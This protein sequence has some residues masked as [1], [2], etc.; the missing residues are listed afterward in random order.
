MY[1]NEWLTR[2]DLA[3]TGTYGDVFVAII[4]MF[5]GMLLLSYFIQ[6]HDMILTLK[7]EV[8]SLQQAPN[9]KQSCSNPVHS[10]DKEDR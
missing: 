7:E 3:I 9:E 10:L 8:E 4:V 1:S 5:A 6:L 2:I